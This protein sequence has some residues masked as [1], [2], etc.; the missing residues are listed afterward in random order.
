MSWRPVY[1][2]EEVAKMNAT[3][4]YAGATQSR[5]PAAWQIMQQLLA[6]TPPS[7]ILDYGS[8]YHAIHTQEFRDVFPEHRFYAYPALQSSLPELLVPDFIVASSVLNVQPHKDAVRAHIAAIFR[9]TGGVLVF[10][11][12]SSPRHA[13]L[14]KAELM[15][16]AEEFFEL[17]SLENNVIVGRP[18]QLP[19]RQGP[20]D[21]Q[22][23]GESHE[24]GLP[25]QAT[26]G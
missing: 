9:G 23:I 15:T 17:K 13:G 25:Y 16:V 24:H 20:S 6:M 21:H 22:P 19:G 11:Y 5:M 1:T 26:D 7:V 4:R 12:P 3:A 8:G 14:S 18:L 10:N 2:F